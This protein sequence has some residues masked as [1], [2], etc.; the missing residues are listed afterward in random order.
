MGGYW[1]SDT[2]TVNSS[3]VRVLTFALIPAAAVIL[4]GL[5]AS[6]RA[7]GARLRSAVQHFAAGLLFA[8]VAGELLPQIMHPAT[9]VASAPLA[10]VLGFALGI[11]L[12]LVVKH[13]TESAGQKGVNQT[14]QPM[15]LLVTLGIDMAIDGLLVGLSFAAGAKQGFLL[16]VALGMEALFLGLSA[17]V[18][19]SKAQASRARIMTVVSSLA[20]L[21]LTGALVGASLSRQLSGAA[22]EVVLSFGC[23]ALLYLVTEELLVEAH[24]APETPI[25]TAMFFVGFVALLVIEMLA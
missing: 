4:G 21:L 1:K 8:A 2:T 3:L 19:L 10:V 13:V 18:A 24:E 23:A 9:S 14:E 12:M 20:V 17:A 6:F 11:G 7:P 5:L 25:L 16:T 15:R 22:L